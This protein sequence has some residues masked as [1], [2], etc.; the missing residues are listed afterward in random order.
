MVKMYAPKIYLE[1]SNIILESIE[2]FFSIDI[3][4]KFTYS[5]PFIY[6]IEK[7]RGTCSMHAC[8]Y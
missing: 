1:E 6:Y 8:S 5:Y 3:K 4:K 2:L 7:Q